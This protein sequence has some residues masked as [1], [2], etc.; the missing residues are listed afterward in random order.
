MATTPTWLAE[1]A[2]IDHAYACLEASR[3]AATA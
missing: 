2:Y 3:Q 1:Q